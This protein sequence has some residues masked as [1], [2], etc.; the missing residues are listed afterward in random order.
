VPGDSAG[1]SRH[2]AGHVAMSSDN[3]CLRFDPQ[4][5]VDQP[6]PRPGQLCTPPSLATRTRLTDVPLGLR[7]PLALLDAFTGLVALLVIVVHDSSLSGS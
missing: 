3:S 2:I 1:Q 4:P 6:F 5:G 7:F